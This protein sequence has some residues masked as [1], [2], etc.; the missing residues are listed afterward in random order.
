MKRYD[1]RRKYHVILLAI[2]LIAALTGWLLRGPAGAAVAGVLSFL[3]LA[4]QLEIVG[5]CYRI[6]TGCYFVGGALVIGWVAAWCVQHQVWKGVKYALTHAKLEKGIRR[7]LLE[8]GYGVAT[9]NQYFR[10][11]QVKIRLE[12]ND[13]SAGIVQ[14]SLIH[15]SEPTRRS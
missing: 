14:L 1:R 10:L 12:G 4:E 7:A 6:G 15:I 11:P 8:A 2:I 13:L 9:G 5:V 3:R